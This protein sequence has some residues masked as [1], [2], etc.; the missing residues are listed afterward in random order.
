MEE[1][2]E[3]IG[4][5]GRAGSAPPPG[6]AD[7][8]RGT[9]RALQD[10]GYR[11]VLEL[12][13]GNGRRAD[14]VGLDRRGLIALVEVKSGLADF[15][16]DGKWPEYIPFCD[17]FY[18]AVSPEFPMR[19]LPPEPGIIVADAFGGVLVRPAVQ[20]PL[21]AARR[22][23]VIVRFARTAAGRLDL[24]VDPRL[25]SRAVDAARAL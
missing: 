8:T 11:V 9:S 14:V 4:E 5:R 22:K 20:T 15:R 21:S 6:A 17:H 18:F 16:C 23:A 3:N 19:E 25:Q 13:L 2:D 12:A 7:I 10:L 24:M 1:Q